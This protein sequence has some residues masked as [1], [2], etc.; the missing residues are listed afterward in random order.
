MS[1]TQVFTA[2]VYGRY[3]FEAVIRDNLDLGRPDRVRLL[4][5]TR[6]RRNTPPPDLGYK[7][8]VITMGA[9]PSLHVEF[10]HSHVKQ[11]FKEHRAHAPRLPSTTKAAS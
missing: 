11:Y 10:E 7:T 3:Y 9:A 6:L 2:P 4:F 8:R 5:P 1:L